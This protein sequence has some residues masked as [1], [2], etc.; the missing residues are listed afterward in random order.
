MPIVC[1]NVRDEPFAEIWRRSPEMLRVRSIRI[2]DL[3]TCSGCAAGRFCAR[4]PGQ[5][6]V[7]N[8]DLYGPSTAACEHALV[9]AEAAGSTAVPASFVSL[10]ALAR[11]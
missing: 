2:R 8:G 10:R 7:E 9:A 4:C 3:H 11:G 6:V 1:G 5:A